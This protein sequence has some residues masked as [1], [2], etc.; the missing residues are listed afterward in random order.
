[1][2]HLALGPLLGTITHLVDIDSRLIERLADVFTYQSKEQPFSRNTMGNL[3]FAILE[4]A[5]TKTASPTRM[6]NTGEVPPNGEFII[7]GLTTQT[8]IAQLYS[9]AILGDPPRRP[10]NEELLQTY[11]IARKHHI[12]AIDDLAYTGKR[13]DGLNPSKYFFPHKLDHSLLHLHA[14]RLVGLAHE[15]GRL[16][17]QPIQ[18]ALLQLTDD[19]SFLPSLGFED[20][21]YRELVSE[22]VRVNA[23]T[24]KT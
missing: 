10:T 17:E 19:P 24:P 18:H 13:L 5:L 7:P 1:M 6:L 2:L 3:V 8:R 21:K 15:A 23:P 16:E 14:S 9:E 12:A 22:L 20:D 11:D 4:P